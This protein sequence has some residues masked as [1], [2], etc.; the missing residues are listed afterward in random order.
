MLCAC[1]N[2]TYL[3]YVTLSS[4]VH[5]LSSM[6]CEDFIFCYAK[7]L[8]RELL[9]VVCSFSRAMDN[10]LKCSKRSSNPPLSNYEI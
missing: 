3:V 9:Q 7:C 2:H 5:T 10:D 6:R 8:S 4:S 1:N